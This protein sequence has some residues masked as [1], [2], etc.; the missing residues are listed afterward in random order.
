MTLNPQTQHFEFGGPAGALAISLG[1]PV[2]TVFLNQMVR[3]DYFVR[4]LFYNFDLAQLWNGIKPLHYYL[5]RYDLWTYYA[6]WFFSL[7]AMSVLLPG[8]RMQG[9]PLRDGTK[10][11]YKIN[12]IA[13]S[14]ALALILA[15]RWALTGGQMPELQF[16]YNNQ[17]D[18]CIITIL[19]AFV[20]S[21]A[22]YIASF[23][24]LMSGPNGTGSHEK[25]L[26]TP[27]STG[28]LI[29]DWFV[30]RELNPRLGPL[31]IKMFC[32]LRPGMLLWLMINL[33]CLHHHYLRTGQ[34]NNALLLL[35]GLQGLY[36][37]D[38]VL[39]EEQVLSMMDI[40]TDGFGFMLAFGDLTLVPF[41]YS[42]Q[43]RYLSVSPV[44]LSWTQISSILA[45]MTIGFYIFKRS[46]TEKA[47]FRAGQLP[48]LQSIPTARGTA[49]LCDGWWALSQHIN[50]FG[51]WLISLSWCLTTGFQTPLTYYY[52]AYFAT[53]LV[54]RQLRDSHKCRV[55]YGASWQEYESK[56][57][58]KIVP[59]LY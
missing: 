54:H 32:E 30:G 56:V 1:L 48:H 53:L 41:T 29:Y 2:F 24:P 23:V 16:L 22:C 19:F 34:V 43:S 36:I 3:P 11:P 57:P 5:T 35:N 47:L 27:G 45:V 52:S 44:D 15:T 9:S 10:L 26:A 42:L 46:N 50:Y 38:G 39:N 40:V 33:S 4:G 18:L 25:I 12:G 59:Y 7:A 49:L 14:S 51:D 31:D 6:V 21:V 8:K 37:M 13:I 20:L 55:K 17:T 58:Y 28:N